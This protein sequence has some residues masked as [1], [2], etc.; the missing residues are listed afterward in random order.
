M[1][2]AGKKMDKKFAGETREELKKAFQNPGF[3][4]WFTE[5]KDSVP[6]LLAQDFIGGKTVNERVNSLAENIKG[7]AILD[8]ETMLQREAKID[9]LKE[10]AKDKKFLKE[11]E[12]KMRKAK[13][14]ISAR[15]AWLEAEEIV[16]KAAEQ[17]E[18]RD[19]RIAKEKRLNKERASEEFKEFRAK[20]PEL[21]MEQPG[22][23]IEEKLGNLKWAVREKEGAEA[24]RT[25]NVSTGLKIA[26]LLAV[27]MEYVDEFLHSEKKLA[28]LK[29]Y[30][31]MQ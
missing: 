31:E 7:H 3:R 15:R 5:W 14:I 2:K 18:L 24:E 16:R 20:F 17:A 21:V 6:E 13:E 25:S 11:I 12:A 23:T 26:A 19:L 1:D 28:G 8:K 30:L 10:A 4:K 29:K 22:A 9:F 27:K